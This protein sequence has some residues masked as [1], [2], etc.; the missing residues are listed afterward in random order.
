MKSPKECVDWINHYVLGGPLKPNPE[1]MNYWNAIIYYLVHSEAYPK[2][3]LK[4]A[5]RRRKNDD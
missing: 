5:I 3:E 1:D 4:E 2:Y